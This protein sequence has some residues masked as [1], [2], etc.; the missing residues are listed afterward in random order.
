MDFTENIKHKADDLMRKAEL[1][2][3]VTITWEKPIQINCNDLTDIETLKKEKALDVFDINKK[4][5][6]IYY[7]EIISDQRNE[8]I[9]KTLRKYKDKKQRSCPKIVRNRSLDSRYLY[10]GSK[11]E[12]LLD[13]FTQH[14]GFGSKD[15]YALQLLYWAKEINL[16]LEFH[17]AWLNPNYKEM[18]ELLESALAEKAKPLVGKLV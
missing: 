14:L 2:P 9:V 12:G 11:K 17:Y 15:T 1:L 18:T 10:C 16:E 6:A 13:R 5:P 3:N 4:H 8:D 7:F